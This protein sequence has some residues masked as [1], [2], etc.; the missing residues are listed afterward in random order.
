MIPGI[1]SRVSN[2]KDPKNPTLRTNYVSGAITAAGNSHDQCT[3]CNSIAKFIY[4]LFLI[5]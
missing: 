5:L 4:N 2:L 3:L 1:R